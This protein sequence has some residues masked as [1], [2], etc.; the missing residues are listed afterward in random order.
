MQITSFL[1]CYLMVTA[2]FGPDAVS[3][4]SWTCFGLYAYTVVTLSMGGWKISQFPIF[5]LL[6]LAVAAYTAATEFMEDGPT[7]EWRIFYGLIAAAMVSFRMESYFNWTSHMSTRRKLMISTW[8]APSEGNI[9][10]QLQIDMTKTLTYIKKKREETNDKITITHV[11][12][13]AVGQL[14]KRTPLVNGRLILGRYYEADS[15]DVGCLV[16]IDTPQGPDLANCKIVDADLKDLK[17]I[18]SELRGKS[19]K[20]RSGNDEEFKK[21]KP[22]LRVLPTFL[23]QPVVSLVGW[24]GA[25]GFTI[26]ALGVKAYPF[27][28]AMVT[29]VGMLGLDVAYIPHTPFAHVPLIVM[30]GAYSKKPVVD[31]ATGKV[32]VKTILPITVTIDHRFL[33]GKTGGAMAKIFKTLLEDPEKMEK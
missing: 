1:T 13:K 17:T 4:G 29:S 8:N 20:L 24:L 15:A 14:L 3:L 22:L 18:S 30:I 7:F 12:I 31:Q 6:S 32:V 11:V 19:K 21:S 25:L 16:S 33:D 28:T 23:I 26:P 9:Y 10:G 27:G 5:V 2:V